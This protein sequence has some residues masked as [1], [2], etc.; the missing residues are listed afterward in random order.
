MLYSL[1]TKYDI[2]KKT[3]S[4]FFI[5][6]PIFAKRV[7]NTG[8]KTTFLHYYK[9]IFVHQDYVAKRYKKFVK[10]LDGLRSTGVHTERDVL[11]YSPLISEERCT[12]HFIQLVRAKSA[13]Q[14]SHM[15][16]VASPAHVFPTV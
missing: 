4:D 2:M 8:K 9:S 12:V 7:Q 11:Y 6:K 3:F 5:Q 16:L 10:S 1:N 14:E 13:L 15:F